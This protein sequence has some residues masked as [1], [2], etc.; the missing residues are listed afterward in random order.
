MTRYT[1]TDQTGKR[2]LCRTYNDAAR[3]QRKL[4]MS[5]HKTTIR[6]QGGK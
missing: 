6:K 2:L 1:L 3:I 5:G 4:A